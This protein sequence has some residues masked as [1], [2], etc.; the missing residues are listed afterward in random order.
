M[1][2]LIFILGNLKRRKSY[3]I[4]ICILIFL[5]GLI[6]TVTTSTM[7][8][9][10]NAFDKA[11]SNMQGPHLLYWFY[12]DS[13][14]KE[15]QEWFEQQESVESVRIRESSFYNGAQLQKDN[16]LLKSTYDISVLEFNPS[17]KL[18]VIDSQYKPEEALKQGEIYLPYIYKSSFTVDVG[19]TI[20][21]VFGNQKISFKVVGFVEELIAGGELDEAKFIYISKPDFT[22]FIKLG[23]DNVEKLLQMRVRLTTNDE[24]VC[25]QLSKKFIKDYGSEVELVKN[26]S[27]IK[28]NLLILPNIALAVMITFAIMLCI[29]T[30]T[31][32]RY[33]IFATIEAD[34]TNIGILKAIGFTP[35]M[36]Q[37]SITGHYVLLTLISGSLSLL[38]GIFVTPILGQIILK[39]SGLFFD[40]FL[41]FKEGILTLMSLIL[42]IGLF[43]FRTA[44][45]T[46]K[47]S[48][49]RAITN[50]LAPVH[51]SSRINLPLDRMKLLP[52]NCCMTLKQLLTKTKRYISFIFITAILAY[53]L[54]FSFGLVDTFRSEKALGILGADFSDIELDTSTKKEAE[55]L[56]SKIKSDYEVEWYYF[57]NSE[58][59]EVDGEKTVINVREDF[60]ASG[61]LH[62]LEGHFPKHD[63]EVAITSLLERRYHK[64]IGDY[65]T[66]KDAN[67]NLHE[68]I[69]TGIYQTVDQGGSVIMMHESGM[70]A[71]DSAYEMNEVYIK[72]TSYDNLDQVIM[73]MQKKYTGY[74]EISNERK[75]QVEDIN[76][77][78]DVFLAISMLV[79]AL[80][81]IIISIITF[82][83]MKITIYGE[84]RELGI[85]KALGFSSSRLRFQLALR[86][87]L[88]TLFGGVIGVALQI[89]TGSKLFLYALHFAGISC[90]SIENKF[91]N[92]FLPIIMITVL[93]LL[94]SYLS[95]KNT[96]VVSAY[97]LINE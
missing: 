2:V 46:K 66:I 6:L 92:A 70:K 69:I 32:M 76:T 9:S 89:I 77:V 26:C 21:F 29:I 10:V 68:F 33:A 91:L 57:E 50:G 81:V 41:S 90:F 58:Q 83:M 31:I 84:T 65:L 53:A 39:S 60:N 5:A 27:E 28:N 95:S 74:E 13:Y 71:L 51:F 16:T 7:K 78:Q 61:A 55:I 44:R 87:A 36:V 38:A 52:F 54:N 30:I 64:H 23:G 37:I 96:K 56:I 40:G 47:I 80:N 17:D 97:K 73:Q 94:S 43:S 82:L 20:D 48:P 34:Y 4:I 12:T 75:D 72:L 25:Y 8:N 79:F 86:F 63:N 42:I 67:S 18:R 45:L 88:I 11:Y 59:L 49:I 15:F 22:K 14:Q 93:T 24:S 3:S 1:A 62:T 35:F 85:Y 19:D